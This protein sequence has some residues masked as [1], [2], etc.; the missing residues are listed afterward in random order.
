MREWWRRRESI[1]CEPCSGED[2][3]KQPPDNCRRNNGQRY[4]LQQCPDRAGHKRREVQ[5]ASRD[6]REHNKNITNSL[7]H[8]L[9][10]IIQKW[11]ELPESARQT[12]LGIVDTFSDTDEKGSGPV[13]VGSVRY[14]KTPPR[15]PSGQQTDCLAVLCYPSPLSPIAQLN[16]RAIAQEGPPHR[17]RLNQ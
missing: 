4:H 12:I 13:T 5:V 1:P 11:D 15:K 10:Q 6:T 17:A 14:L 9:Q 2:A 7:P 3:P 8:R 16:D